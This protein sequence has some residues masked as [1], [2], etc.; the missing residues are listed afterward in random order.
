MFLHGGWL[1]IIGNMAFLR[2]FG[3]D[4]EDVLGRGAYLIFYLGAGVV[5]SL[6]H[7]FMSW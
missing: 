3:D 4:I 1:H 5:A 7:I 2:V 6:V